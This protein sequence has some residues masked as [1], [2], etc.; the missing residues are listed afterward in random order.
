MK[1]L[2]LNGGP[3]KKGTTRTILKEL[4]YVLEGK[5]EVKWVDVYDLEMKPCMGCLKCR[6]DGACVLPE[7]GAHVVGGMIDG[8]DA[9]VVGTP[10]YW[11]NMTGPLKILFD[12]SVPRIEY[13][14]GGLP[15]PNHKGKPGIIVTSSATPW[16]F[17]LIK[18]QSGGAVRSVKIVLKSG[19]YRIRGIIN[20]PNMKRRPEIPK[21]YLK[22][23][24]KL[25]ERL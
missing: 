18:S 17:N 12:R 10:T 21:K 2:V 15:R 4:V 23:A 19:G 7:D 1:I 25:G 13:I 8:A 11:G 24:R 14:G 9:L 5:H 6:P 20:V 16:P 22:Q 3:R